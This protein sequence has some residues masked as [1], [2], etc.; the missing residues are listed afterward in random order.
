MDELHKKQRHFSCSERDLTFDRDTFQTFKFKSLLIHIPT[1]RKSCL[2][3]D[4]FD[5]LSLTAQ[6]SIIY[7]ASVIVVVSVVV[8]S[9][10]AWLRRF[11]L[12]LFS[13]FT[14]FCVKPAFWSLSTRS[15]KRV[16]AQSGERSNRLSKH[17]HKLYCRVFTISF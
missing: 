14:L 4:S 11:F 7:F 10:L 13:F 12:R 5:V 1:H 2:Q 8:S 9:F 16:K 17:T 6:K 15:P 3:Y